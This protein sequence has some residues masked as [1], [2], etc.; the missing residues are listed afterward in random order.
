VTV[1]VS[2][3]VAVEAARLCRLLGERLP[4]YRR[5]AV[6]LT[7]DDPPTVRAFWAATGWYEP[8]AEFGLH[9]PER[10]LARSAVP[11]LLA[12]HGADGDWLPSRYRLVDVD[13][14]GLGFRMTDEDRC[15]DDPPLLAVSFDAGVDLVEQEHPRYLVWCAN[16]MLAA[17]HNSWHRTGLAPDELGR[18]ERAEAPFPTL[19]PVTRKLSDDVWL[20]PASA[21]VDYFD[22]HCCLVYRDRDALARWRAG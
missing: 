10:A 19:S 13:P 21:A 7:E 1:S 6:Q 3:S 2:V 12:G 22:E 14:D 20:V 8:F 5:D 15:P 11:A 9:R 16:A 17:A 18:V 4:G